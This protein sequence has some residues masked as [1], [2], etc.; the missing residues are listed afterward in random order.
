M[1]I[2]QFKIAECPTCM[3]QVAENCVDQNGEEV[4]FVH[5]P[6]I[7]KYWKEEEEARKNSTEK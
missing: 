1:S 2:S 7:Q 4:T 6:R 5:G 3:A